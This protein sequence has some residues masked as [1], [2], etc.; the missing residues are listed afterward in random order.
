M[1]KKFVKS[2]K[3]SNT[4]L[5][6]GLFLSHPAIADSRYEGHQMTVPRVSAIMRVNCIFRFEFLLLLWDPLL[7][8]LKLYGTW[9]A[10]TE[11]S[12]I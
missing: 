1:K 5:E 10:T 12:Y 6:I 11:V 3:S 2:K 4:K 8:V 7:K 9:L